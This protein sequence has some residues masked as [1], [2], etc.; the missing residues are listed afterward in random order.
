MEL[1]VT[2]YQTPA[3]GFSCKSTETLRVEQTT[4][5][6]LSV[7]KT[8]QF[9]KMLLLD[10]MVMTTEKDE[11]VYH[12]MISLVACNSHPRPENVL[13][14]GG[15]D[16]GTLREVVRHPAVKHGT[17]VE[18]DERV[19]QASRDFFPSL[20]CAF[21]DAKSQ[22]LIEDGIKY[23]KEHKNCYD[24]VIVDSTDPVGPAVEL[25]SKSFYENVFEVLKDDGML[26][27]QSDSPYYHPDVV[28]M[29]YNGIAGIFP[30]TRLYLAN[31]PTYPS[32]LWSFT[33]GSKKYAPENL[34]H[35]YDNGCRYYTRNLHQAAFQLPALVQ[36]IISSEE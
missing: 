16:G 10:G 15:G 13:I 28:K 30:L 5:Q 24:I 34:V 29:A 11:F 18:I 32:G 4:F 25:F 8:E 3:I 23:V 33:I 26:V 19:V 35:E 17:L 22:V 31:I 7:I 14:I 21:E 6:H 12:E 2:E 27:V 36:K 1:W 9:G 20:S